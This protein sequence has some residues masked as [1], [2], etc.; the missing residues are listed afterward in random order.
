VAFSDAGSSW[1]APGATAALT[2]DSWSD[3]AIAFTVP[4]TAGT[5]G[6]GQVSPG[7]TAAVTVAS[8]AGAI[9]RTA[10]LGITP[11]AN[12]ADYADDTGTSPDTDQGCANLDGDGF[13]YSAQTL[14][15]AG[16]LPGATVSSGGL[17]YT[18]PSAAAC[19]PDNV[20][21][22]AQTVLMRGTRGDTTLGLL[23]SST[24][25][26]AQGT[27]L[28]HYRDGSTSAEPVSIGDWAGSTVSGDTTVAALPY[29]N[30]Q[31]GTSDQLTV[32]VFAATVPVDPART[33]TSV[34][35]PDIG[36]T[37]APSVPALHIF[38]LALGS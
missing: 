20:V 13:S 10:L 22:G 9:S 25:G 26:T 24:S 34:T 31:S 17:S 2:I 5:G 3:R 33:V 38:S 14:A 8:A 37:V 21:A 28:I 7:T 15:A 12:L 32:R 35:L 29:R 27:V 23:G 30:S 1:G 36:Y 16:L 6:T 18:W 4:A 11:T 19:R